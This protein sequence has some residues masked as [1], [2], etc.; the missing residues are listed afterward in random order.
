MSRAVN[1]HAQETWV[2]DYGS[3]HNL[4]V[5]KGVVLFNG[6][7]L[8]K[9]WRIVCENFK[10]VFPEAYHEQQGNNFVTPVP[11]REKLEIPPMPKKWKQGKN[12]K[13]RNISKEDMDALEEEWKS[14]HT[15]SIRPAKVTGI[16]NF[17]FDWTKMFDATAIS[18]SPFLK[19]LVDGFSK[20]A[21]DAES[22]DIYKFAPKKFITA[23]LALIYQSRK[24]AFLDSVRKTLFSTRKY[25]TGSG[26]QGQRPQV[27]IPAYRSL[28]QTAVM[29]ALITSITTGITPKWVEDRTKAAIANKSVAANVTVTAQVYSAPPFP[30]FSIYPI[31]ENKKKGDT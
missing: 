7:S 30:V 29:D 11:P 23:A 8:F 2:N 26:P 4:T 6:I 14:S 13:N 1:D 15:P 21:I 27:A 16:I 25:T 17:V 9:V 18:G 12:S 19:S 31:S 10:S 3:V 22:V 24:K 28:S 20:N 5:E